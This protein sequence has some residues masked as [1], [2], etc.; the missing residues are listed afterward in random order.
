[1]RDTL[2]CQPSFNRLGIQTVVEK[3]RNGA[4]SSADTSVAFN[5]VSVFARTAEVLLE[6]QT[7]TLGMMESMAADWLSNRRKQLDS[8]REMVQ[9][10]SACQDPAEIARIQQ[11]W[12]TDLFQHATTEVSSVSSNVLAVAAQ[13]V[14]DQN[15]PGRNRKAA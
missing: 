5:A 3:I 13:A 1:V 7:H 15:Q 6:R 2:L 9:Q 14:S 4:T 8:M 10:I 12:L 11:R